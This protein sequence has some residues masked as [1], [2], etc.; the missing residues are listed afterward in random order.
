M[1]FVEPKYLKLINNRL[2]GIFSQ[3][4]LEVDI[5]TSQII[6]AGRYT[7][8]EQAQIRANLINLSRQLDKAY[9]D[10]S[11][12][13]IPISYITGWSDFYVSKDQIR[14]LYKQ[15]KSRPIDEAKSKVDNFINN[16]MSVSHTQAVQSLVSES[17]LIFETSISTLTWSVDSALSTITKSNIFNT[18][19]KWVIKWESLTKTKQAVLKWLME[20]WLASVKTVNGRKI[21]LKTYAETITRTETMKA[22]N[23][24]FVYSALD[25]GFTKLIRRES[26]NCCEICAPHRGERRNMLKQWQPYDVLH[27]NCGGGRDIDHT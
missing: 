21:N 5:E 14:D 7:A 22:Y 12:L 10:R 1:E 3:A 16:S 27:P 4:I 26:P 25:N 18:L 19:A 20:W 24:W 6:Q 15:I 9:K 13:S 8:T 17:V 2:L 11:S 23:R